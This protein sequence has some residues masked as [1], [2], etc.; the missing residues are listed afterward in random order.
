MA[1]RNAQGERYEERDCVTVEI[2][3]RQGHVCATK[4]R[5]QDNKDGAYKVSYFAKETEN[6]DVWH[7]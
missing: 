2:T 1:T 5:V 4:A 6:E 3:N 7:Q